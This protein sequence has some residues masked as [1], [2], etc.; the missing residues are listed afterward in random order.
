[1][2]GSAGKLVRVKLIS[3][4]QALRRQGRA[5]GGEVHLNGSEGPKVHSVLVLEVTNAAGD[6]PEDAGNVQFGM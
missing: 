2:R 3:A 4:E 6:R 5:G 1:M